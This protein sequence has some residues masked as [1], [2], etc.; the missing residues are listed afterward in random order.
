MNLEPIGQFIAN[1]GAWLTPIL[2]TI[3]SVYCA[4]KEIKAFFTAKKERKRNNVTLSLLKDIASSDSAAQAKA[5]AEKIESLEKENEQLKQLIK[6][7]S[8]V[9]RAQSSVLGEMFSIVFENSSLS[10]EVKEKLRL[11]KT[12]IDCPS[13]SGM[14]EELLSQNTIL[15]EEVKHMEQEREELKKTN[16]VKIVNDAV[17]DTVSKKSVTQTIIQ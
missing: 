10:P 2:L 11:L 8:S 17:A 12:K 14:L 7:E 1:A 4:V 3:A 5:N 9:M 13:E 15:R 6:T 16:D